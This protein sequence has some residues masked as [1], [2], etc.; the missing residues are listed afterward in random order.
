MRCGPE[1]EA[2]LFELAA[3]FAD[4]HRGEAA[5]AS[6]RGGWPGMER[7]VRVGGSGHPAGRGVRVR[8]AGC[9]VADESLVGAAAGRRRPGRAAPA[10]VD[11]GPGGRRAGAGLQRPAGGGQDP[12]PVVGGGRRSWTPRWSSTW[13]GRCR[14]AGSRPGWTARS[15]PRTRRWRRCGRT[16]GWP[17]S[18]RKRTRSSEAGHRGV[19]RALHGRGDRPAGGHRR[20]PRRRAGARSGTATPR[21]CA[22][23]RPSRCWP[24]RSGPWSCWPRSPRCRADYRSTSSRCPT[25]TP[26]DPMT[27]TSRAIRPPHPRTRW[28]GWTPSPAG[29]GS[30]HAGSRTG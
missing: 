14:G 9:A 20:V 27:P 2:A 26:D 22:G 23:S 16:P 21:T 19:L 28:P 8:G 25:P 3:V 6:G 1:A 30:P 7:S 17:S 13:T 24:T 5:A 11:L 15:W 29:S 4:Q 12:A 18:S 10:A